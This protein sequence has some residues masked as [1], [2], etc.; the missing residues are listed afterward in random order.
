MPT[1]A[2]TRT[3]EE[4]PATPGVGQTHHLHFN[5]LKGCWLLESSWLVRPANTSNDQIQARRRRAI[6]SLVPLSRSKHPIH[7]SAS[8]TLPG[9]LEEVRPACLGAPPG[10]VPSRAPPKHSLPDQSETA[11]HTMRRCRSPHFHRAPAT[12]VSTGAPLGASPLTSRSLLAR[13]ST[14][15]ALSLTSAA[16]PCVRAPSVCAA[17]VA[18]G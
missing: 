4:P 1:M 18:R 8:S 10:P 17:P 2:A 12:G 7:C 3:L 5:A 13:Y 14:L 6:L 11:T 9:K 16:T 15:A